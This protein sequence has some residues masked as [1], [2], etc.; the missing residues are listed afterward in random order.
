MLRDSIGV[1][2]GG[3]ALARSFDRQAGSQT[4][5]RKSDTAKATAK[6]SVEIKKAE[7]QPCRNCHGNGA[8]L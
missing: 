4:A 5:D 3:L 8:R 7:M 1:G 6:A 2:A